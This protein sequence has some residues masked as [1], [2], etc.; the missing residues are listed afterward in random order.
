LDDMTQPLRLLDHRSTPEPYA[1]GR[2]WVAVGRLGGVGDNLIASSPLPLLAAK[3][4]VEVITQKP[5]HVIFENNPYIAKLTVLEPSHIPEGP[6]NEWQMWWV[7][8]AKEYAALFNLSHSCE[9]EVA[10]HVG[11]PNFARSDAYRRKVANRN[12]LEIVHDM[13]GVPYIFE[14]GPRFYPTSEES[15][16]ARKTLAEAAH[17][18][19]TIGWCLSGTRLD[20]M[21]THAPVAVARLIH[22]LGADVFL[23]GAP[24]RDE[25]IAKMIQE[26]VELQCGAG[27]LAHLH[28]CVSPSWENQTWHIR[29]LLSTVMACHLVIGPDTGPMWAVAMEDMPKI[30]LLGHASPENI[31]KHWRRTVT[32][33]GGPDVDCWPC[34]KL[35][36]DKTTCRPDKHD[37]GAACM[38]D[39]EPARIVSIAAQFLTD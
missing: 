11:H 32:L 29:R 8:R 6:N 30:L 19:P 27:D 5:H 12:Y 2:E 7:R 39:I 3:Y 34:H 35:H 36:N 24:G 17:G 37:R 21:Y 26:F 23:F 1:F 13:C 25:H 22:D 10:F 31:T 20:K 28:T 15:T 4:N 38:S 16:L 18:R 33:H 14:P 9:T